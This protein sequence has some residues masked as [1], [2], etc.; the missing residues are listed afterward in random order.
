MG[1]DHFK[2]DGDKETRLLNKKTVALQLSP[3]ASFWSRP[4]IRLFVTKANWNNAA[5]NWNIIGQGVFGPN[6]VTGT[7]AGEQIEAWW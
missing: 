4:V 1:Q 3:Q 5:N 7:T 6:A 2:V